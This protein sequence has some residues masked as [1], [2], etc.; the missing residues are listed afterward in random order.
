MGRSPRSWPGQPDVPR[1]LVIGGSGAIG[2]AIADALASRGYD[3]VRTSR[4]G[5]DGCRA[6][7]PLAD[8]D[9]MDDVLAAGPFDAVVWAQGA[10]RNDAAD[11]VDVDGFRAMLDANVTFVAASM[12]RLVADGAVADG[13]RMVVIS[14]I[15]QTLARADKFSY[16]VSKAAV[17]GLV[18]AASVDLAPRGI[19]VNAVL[20]SVIDTAMTRAML[21]AEQVD[22]VAG[23][24]GFD[25]LNTTG[26]VAAMVMS[27]CT[28]A[29]TG[30]T[31]QSIAVDLGF[32]H[33]RVI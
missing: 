19:L 1:A 3:V 5:G 31:G 20:P 30:V 16:T 25:R 6:L 23:Q 8:P 7:D 13:A 11:T 18:R 14:S 29:N 33:A 4:G 12:Q 24:T 15:W 32:S 21:S 9:S 17:G 10:N 2:G 28:D 26:D 27:L 22:H